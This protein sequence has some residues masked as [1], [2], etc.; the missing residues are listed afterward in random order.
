MPRENTA[1]KP[2]IPMNFA[3]RSLSNTSIANTFL[4]NSKKAVPRTSPD[5]S[6][7]KLRQQNELGRPFSPARGRVS[8]ALPDSTEPPRAGDLTN[9]VPEQRL[10]GDMHGG[11][12][13]AKAEAVFVIHVVDEK[14]LVMTAKFGVH[15]EVNQRTGV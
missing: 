11:S 13:D 1:R 4:G 10:G 14:A 9:L 3:P 5:R 6:P 15:R 2:I 12:H 8:A 7:V